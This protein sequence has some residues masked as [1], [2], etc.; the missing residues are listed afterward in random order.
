LL[1]YANIHGN[2][3]TFERAKTIHTKRDKPEIIRAPLLPQMRHIIE[4][5]GNESKQSN[6]YIFTCLIHRLTAER[7]R[8]LIKY[9]TKNINKQ[10]KKIA[11]KLGI[12]ANLTTYVA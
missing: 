4:R 8:E 5:W 7:E 12:E 6:D 1:K 11:G 9:Q 2:L 10:M 3:I